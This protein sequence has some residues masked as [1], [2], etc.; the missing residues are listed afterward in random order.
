MDG[1]KLTCEFTFNKKEKRKTFKLQCW[2]ALLSPVLKMCCSCWTFF[3]PQN[4]HCG[5]KKLNCPLACAERRDWWAWWSP[6]RRS[7]KQ[8]LLFAVCGSSRSVWLP[9]RKVALCPAQ[10]GSRAARTEGWKKCLNVTYVRSG[11]TS[12]SYSWQILFNLWKMW[13]VLFKN[14]IRLWE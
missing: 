1:L 5:F 3:L 12:G 9:F 13:R 7:W 6:W 11:I 14:I 8:E 2:G 4:G 10:N